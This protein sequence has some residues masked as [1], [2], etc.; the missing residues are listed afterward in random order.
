MKFLKRCFARVEQANRTNNFNKI[1]HRGSETCLTRV[2]ITIRFF[3][4]RV[5]H[6]DCKADCIFRH[7]SCKNLGRE[8]KFG[9]QV[10]A[11]FQKAFVGD[12]FFFA[13]FN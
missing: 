8:I 2:L 4:A 9:S 10:F 3:F 13:N 1:V 6:I 7:K 12:P 5:F 11:I